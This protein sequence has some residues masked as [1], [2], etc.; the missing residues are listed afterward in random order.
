MVSLD[1]YLKRTAKL[2]D[3][4]IERVFPRSLSS[5]W[6]A[7]NLGHLEF[8]LDSVALNDSVSK[9]IYDFLDRGGKRWRAVL[10]ILCGEVFG[11]D[12][13]KCLKFS[14]IPEL[15]HNGTIMVDDVEDNSV[16]RRGRPSSHLIFG[17]DVA[18]NAANSLYYLPLVLL[19]NSN[20][21]DSLK[22]SI[23]DSYARHLLRLS[24]GQALDISWH[25]SQKVPSESEY[26]QM[27]VY[28]TGSLAAFASELGAIVASASKSEISAVSSFASSIGVAFQI[29]DDVL[30][31]APKKGWGKALGDD[32][33]EGKKTL[34]VIHALKNL[35]A[36]DSSRLIS[37][38]SSKNIS[39]SEV[40]EAISLIKSAG[41]L[42]Y[43]LGKA[44]DL[45][46]S[47]WAK[48]EPVLP[49]SNAKALL[50]DFASFMVDRQL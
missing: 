34:L 28:K 31:I 23:Y 47:S 25:K 20:L 22:A 8:G 26:L 36:K 45:L 42:D 24:F 21:D 4:E 13:D 17:V 7:S 37:I 44:K 35:S 19:F 2:V 6:V 41:S 46:S 5:S 33:R 11:A 1:D 32:I 39:D 9:P 40:S 30:N 14:V 12:F 43:A 49:S 29:Y 10:C 15:V 3:S 16:L 48:L 50:K 18:V 38:L 27:C